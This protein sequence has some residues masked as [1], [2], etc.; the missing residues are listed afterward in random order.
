MQDAGVK[1]RA[2]TPPVKTGGV[3]VGHPPGQVAAV[4]GV[5]FG[6]PKTGKTTLGASGEGVLHLGFDPDGDL[7]ETLRGRT[8]ITVVR[9]DSLKE[10]QQIVKALHSTDRGRFPWVLVDSITFLFALADGGEIARTYEEGKDIRR[11]YGQAGAPVAQIVY[12]LCMLKETNVIFTAHLQKDSQ[13]DGVPLETNLGETDVKVAVTPMV[14]K[15]LG[16]AV[17]FIGRTYKKTVWDKV[18]G[19]RNKRTLYA[20]SF[21]DGERS[22]AGSRLPMEA[23]YEFGPNTRLLQ[24]LANELTTGGN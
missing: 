6:P 14:W 15:T 19:K 4:K 23:A 8:D 12:D 24:E 9:P 10:T 20:V 17:S 13:D 11:A 3:I 2:G 5:L 18:D 21:N 22:P 1:K 16:P 7:T